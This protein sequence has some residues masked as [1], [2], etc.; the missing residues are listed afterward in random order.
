MTRK[1]NPVF[2]SWRLCHRE[3]GSIPFAATGS[4]PRARVEEMAFSSVRRILLDVNVFERQ[5]G[6]GVVA[7][8]MNGAGTGYVTGFAVAVG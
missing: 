7:L 1:T 6:L 4:S 5:I 3:W 8:E 2:V